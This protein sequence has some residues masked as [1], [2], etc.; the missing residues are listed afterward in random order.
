[1]LAWAAQG[2]AGSLSLEVLKEHGDVALRDVGGGY[3][4]GGL[5]LEV[6]QVFS[7]LCGSMICIEYSKLEE[8]NKDH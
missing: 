7:N 8:T 2:V 3:G 1:M 4:R 6:L 5:G